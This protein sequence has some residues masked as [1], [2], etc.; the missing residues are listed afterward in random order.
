MDVWLLLKGR[1]IVGLFWLVKKYFAFLMR[2]LFG[3]AAR[4]LTV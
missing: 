2:D 4:N 3:L 1:R